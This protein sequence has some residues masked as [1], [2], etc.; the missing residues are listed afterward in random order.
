MGSACLVTSTGSAASYHIN[1]ARKYLLSWQ[2][3]R[4]R[5]LLRLLLHHHLLQGCHSNKP[6]TRKK[7]EFHET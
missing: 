6:I 3:L 7:G 1:S 4:L 5:P 2:C